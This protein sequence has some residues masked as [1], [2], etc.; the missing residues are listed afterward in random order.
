MTARN[1]GLLSKRAFSLV[2]LSIVLVILGLLVGGVLSG[3]SLIRAAELRSVITQLQKFTAANN[4]FK[5]KYLAVA[6]D[7]ANATQFWQAADATGPTQCIIALVAGVSG[8]QTCNGNGDGYV[9]FSGNAWPE[10][11]L[12]WQHL[13]SAGLIEGKYAGYHG[14]GIGTCCFYSTINSPQGRISNSLWVPYSWDDTP[15]QYQFGGQTPPVSGM[16][17]GSATG[18]ILRPEEL[19]NIDTKLDDGKPNTGK[20]TSSGGSC[21]TDATPTASYLLTN[22][23]ISCYAIFTIQ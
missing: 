16:P 5:D 21:L 17:A 19:W 7:M 9:G 13:A 22:S 20:V 15:M 2:E 6:G 11:A 14:V 8:S 3:Q 4:S 18:N 12:Y 1:I 23:D 10:P